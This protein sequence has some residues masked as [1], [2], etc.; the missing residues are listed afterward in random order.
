MERAVI[1][2]ISLHLKRFLEVCNHMK[3]ESVAT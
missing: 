3:V 1:G 2:L